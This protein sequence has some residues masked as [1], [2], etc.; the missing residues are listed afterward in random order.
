M[1]QLFRLAMLVT[2]QYRRGVRNAYDL[3]IRRETLEL[4]ALPEAFDGLRILHMTDLHLDG[5]TRLART[6]RQGL[7]Q[8]GQVDLALLTGDYKA[9]EHGPPG[10]ALEAMQDVVEAIPSREG[11]L[12]VLGNHDSV[13]M[14]KPLEEMGVQVLINNSHPLRRG[15][16]QIQFIGTDDVHYYYT[17]AALRALEAA[18]EGF[19]IAMI[20]S[21]EL[22]PEAARCGV[23]L[24][25]CGHTHG[26]QVCL[27]G[28]RAVV[29]HLS[30]CRRLHRGLWRLDRM[31]G[32]TGTG[33]GTS[34]VPIRFQCP[35]ELAVLTLRRSRGD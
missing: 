18:G 10:P 22:A 24:Y 5:M 12:A 23:D 14:V 34:S 8:I 6:V 19:T 13:E 27:P 21:P 1:A 32:R 25:L 9:S 2:F 20:H 30:R 17:P 4:P 29:T 11:V 15:D 26:G 33:V 31:L 7:K 28:G 3:Q 35:P 16:Q